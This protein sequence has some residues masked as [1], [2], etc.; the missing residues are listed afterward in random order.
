MLD[1]L[2]RR[3]DDHVDLMAQDQVHK[4]GRRLFQLV[5]TDG[6]DSVLFKDAGGSPGSVDTVSQRLE[7]SGN[8]NHFLL[9][10]VFY[11]N[12]HIAVFRK[13]DTGSQEGFIKSLVKGL[14]DSQTFSC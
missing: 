3:I 5:G 1:S 4:V 6:F 8:G 10:L 12:D 9:I 2:R 13:T 7:S 14:R 11:R